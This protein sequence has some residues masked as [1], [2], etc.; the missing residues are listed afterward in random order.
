[1]ITF[2]EQLKAIKEATKDDPETQALCIAVMEIE[3]DY[4]EDEETRLSMIDNLIKKSVEE[5]GKV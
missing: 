2:E 5:N 1:M 4:R 3:R